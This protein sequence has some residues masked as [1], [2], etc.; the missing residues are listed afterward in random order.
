[1]FKTGEEGA[2][3]LRRSTL[4]GKKQA[5][6]LCLLPNYANLFYRP[7]ARDQSIPYL[8]YGYWRSFSLAIPIK[9]RCVSEEFLVR[10]FAYAAY[11]TLGGKCE[12]L[13]AAASGFAY[14]TGHC[15]FHLVI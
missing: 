4:S 9:K 2:D 8:I 13:L 1:M 3:D 5:W 7:S 15:L 10:L 14:A 11:S 6:F 12:V